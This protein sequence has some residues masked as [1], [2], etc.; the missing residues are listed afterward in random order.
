[1]LSAVLDRAG[2]TPNNQVKWGLGEIPQ[3]E[4]EC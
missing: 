1:M 4:F 2:E 3:M